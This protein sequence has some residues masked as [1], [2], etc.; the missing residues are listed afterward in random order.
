MNKKVLQKILLPLLIPGIACA[1][2]W[3]FWEQFQPFAWFLFYPAV[4]FSAQ[5]GGRWGGLTAKTHPG[6]DRLETIHRIR[7]HKDLSLASTPVIA[8]TALAMS[9]DRERCL[10]AGANEYMSKPLKLGE[11]AQAIRGILAKE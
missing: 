5:I 2:Q 1:I 8:V 9:E 7:A 10:N 4:F 11:L 3:I 6:M